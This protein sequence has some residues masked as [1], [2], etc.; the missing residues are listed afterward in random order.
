MAPILLILALAATPAGAAVLHKCVDAQGVASYQS[1]PCGPGQ[2]QAWSR[3]VPPEPARPAPAPPPT[4]ARPMR[5]VGA[6]G[7]RVLPPTR[8]D[9]GQAAC[10]SAREADARYRQRPLSEIRFAELRRLGD[11]IH[12]ACR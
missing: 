4:P 3:P 5:V 11:A 2:A 8:R 7:S 9:A 6:G 10:R 1:L 12:R